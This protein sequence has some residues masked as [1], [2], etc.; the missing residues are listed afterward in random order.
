MRE[1]LNHCLTLVLFTLTYPLGYFFL[2]KTNSSADAAGPRHFF[3]THRG[4]TIV[5][6]F[7]QLWSNNPGVEETEQKKYDQSEYDS[8][9]CN[10]D[11]MTSQEPQYPQSASNRRKLLQSH[12]LLISPSATGWNSCLCV[13]TVIHKSVHGRHNRSFVWQHDT[14][15]L[16]Q[17][18]NVQQSLVSGWNFNWETR[19]GRHVGACPPSNWTHTHT[20]TSSRIHQVLCSQ[21]LFFQ[22]LFQLFSR[23]KVHSWFWPVA[24]C[25]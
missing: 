25:R 3:K 14:M 13:G 12:E 16:L 4:S 2:I 11:S 21:S 17:W 8:K 23:C 6:R 20:H 1:V 22:P 18:E 15:D 10:N 9:C 24:A 7:G 5:A 19:L